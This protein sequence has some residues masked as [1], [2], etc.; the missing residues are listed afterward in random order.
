MIN[1]H[2]QYNINSPNWVMVIDLRKCVG[3][4]A[5]TV[6]CGI[7]NATP[8]GYFRTFVTVEEISV[9]S[10]I[11]RSI[12]PRTCNHCANAACVKVCP[13]KATYKRA[14]G[15]VVVDNTRCIGCGYCVQTCPYQAR[16]INPVTRTADKCSYCLHRLEAGLLPACV[17]SCVGG[18]RVFGDLANPSCAAGRLL[19]TR[20][21]YVL[22]EDFGTQPQVFYIGPQQNNHSSEVMARTIYQGVSNG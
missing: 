19:E 2:V 11:R 18:A 15:I 1:S 6:A 7:E 12:I 8:V 3:C 10:Q 20:H 17:E 13:T 14:D 16:F 4:Q 5:C 21:T 9:G 22:K